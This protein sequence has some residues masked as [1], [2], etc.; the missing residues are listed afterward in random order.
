MIIIIFRAPS[1]RIVASMWWFFTLIMVSSYTAN[2]A[3]FLT[4]E[5]P[6]ILI[7][8]AEELQKLNGKIAY[9]AKKVGST[10]NFF[11]DSENEIYQKMYQYMM[12]H[13]ENMM[14]TNEDGLARAKQGNYAFLMESSTINYMAQRNCEVVKVGGE[15]DEKGYGIAMKKGKFDIIFKDFLD[16]IESIDYFQMFHIVVHYQK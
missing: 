1:T 5:S 7:N 2:L 13:K 6:F 12:D 8:N 11:K 16:L 14:N 15:L 10:I 9:G 4:V 3:A